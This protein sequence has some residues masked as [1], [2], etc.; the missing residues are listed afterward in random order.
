ME[1]DF[2]PSKSIKL[3]LLKGTRWHGRMTTRSMA[4]V[5]EKEDKLLIAPAIFKELQR[6]DIIGFLDY[7][8][9][10]VVVHR[11]HALN[12]KNKTFLTKGDLGRVSDKHS[13]PDK[14]IGKVVEI[15]KSDGK[16]ISLSSLKGKILNKF[17][18]Y[19]SLINNVPQLQR[20]TFS[21]RKRLLS[22]L[23]SYG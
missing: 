21:T 5:I 22:L 10:K 4:P 16:K 23:F 1:F 2:V 3:N 18:L 9:K 7:K 14:V 20:F 13:S 11:L 6:G 19:L 17:C 8:R 12:K 15:I